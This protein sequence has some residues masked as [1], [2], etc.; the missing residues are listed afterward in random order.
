MALGANLRADSDANRLTSSAYR[1]RAPRLGRPFGTKIAICAVVPV[2][3]SALTCLSLLLCLVLSQQI[4][5]Q[6]SCRL[7][8]ASQPP[9]GDLQHS[10]CIRLKP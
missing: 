6:H 7:G 1:T 2:Q 4:L 8:R 5:E 10:N 3:R 9:P